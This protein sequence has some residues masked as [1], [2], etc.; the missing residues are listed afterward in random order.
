MLTDANARFVPNF[1]RS[2]QRGHDRIKI[3]QF[4]LNRCGTRGGSLLFQF[5]DCVYIH[6]SANFNNSPFPQIFAI[7][8]A[9]L[10]QHE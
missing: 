10:T 1:C 7:F 5:K 6:G 4:L 9:K 8:S 3:P 2:T